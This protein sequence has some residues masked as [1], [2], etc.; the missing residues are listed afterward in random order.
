MDV[1]KEGA[2]GERRL[3]AMFYSQKN[4]STTTTASDTARATGSSPVGLPAPV[5][6]KDQREDQKTSVELSS[7]ARADAK[8]VPFGAAE[9]GV[10]TN[11]GTGGEGDEERGEAEATL[12]RY[13]EL[14]EAER[15]LQVELKKDMDTM[16]EHGLQ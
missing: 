8:E 10:S 13:R 5:M 12:E 3:S 2:E 4:P 14:K 1:P 9:E 15:M 16:R 7:V 6:E 11:P